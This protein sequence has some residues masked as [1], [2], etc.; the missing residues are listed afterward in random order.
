MNFSIVAQYCYVLDIVSIIILA[1]K[2]KKG[3]EVKHS[4]LAIVAVVIL[5]MVVLSIAEI[6]YR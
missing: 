4:L 6:F 3:K 1:F 5:G 2:E